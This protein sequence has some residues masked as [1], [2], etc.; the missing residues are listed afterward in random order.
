MDETY[1][2]YVNRVA[3]LTLPTS[4]QNQLKN[5]QK[6]PKF[7]QK[8]P[9]SFP[10]Y[11]VLTPP[12]QDDSTNPSFYEQ[13]TLIQ[14]QLIEKIEPNLLIPV[15][16]ESF[17]L[18][19]ADLIWE[20]NYRN[21]INSDKN[22]DN[23]L[24]KAITDSFETYQ[25]ID[26]KKGESQWQILGLLVFPRALVV[27]LVPCN[28]LSYNKIYQLRRSIYQNEELIGLGI[29]QQYYLTAHITLGY[30]DEITDELDKSNLESIILSFNDQWIEKEPQI[31][32]IR[33]GELRKFENMTQFILDQTNPKVTI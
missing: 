16:P 8:Q 27:G 2:M 14:Q 22:F 25:K 1:Q 28:E 6:S 26:L 7:Q 33:Q 13:L 21:A 18:T 17:H 24:K 5:I 3:S 12:Y 11:T 32:T 23:K 4:Y 31:L 19:L 20:D 10:G 29:E 30:F 15:P 9:V